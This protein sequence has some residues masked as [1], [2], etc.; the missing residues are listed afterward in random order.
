MFP[1][2]SRWLLIL[3]ANHCVSFLQHSYSAHFPF[4]LCIP[5]DVSWVKHELKRPSCT[6]CKGMKKKDD[7]FRW[8]AFAREYLLKDKLFA[9]KVSKERERS[10][11]N[12][13]AKKKVVILK[14][15]F[16]PKFQKEI[17]FFFWNLFFSPEVF[18]N[19]FISPV[20][21]N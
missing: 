7:P 3:F 15:Y 16:K 6:F 14:S 10:V 18:C 11:S 5:L 20:I 8:I 2:T 19:A 1:L 17:F 4:Y 12:F 21:F 13:F 9:N